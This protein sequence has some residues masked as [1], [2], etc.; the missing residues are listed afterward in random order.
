MR[1][2]GIQTTIGDRSVSV[3]GED[4]EAIRTR[5]TVRA[6]DGARPQ[7]LLAEATAQLAIVTALSSRTSPIEG[8]FNALGRLVQAA[9][10][11]A[12]TAT[13][14]AREV[15]GDRETGWSP[16]GLSQA[17]RRVAEAAQAPEPSG[18][19]EVTAA[20]QTSRLSET[21]QAIRRQ[22]G[23]LSSASPQGTGQAAIAGAANATPASTHNSSM[24]PAVASLSAQVQQMTDALDDAATALRERR[25]SKLGSRKQALELARK[26]AKE[27]TKAGRHH[28]AWKAER[29]RKHEL[30]A[31]EQQT[32]ADRHKRVA[33]AYERARVHAKEARSAY[34][35][36][37]RILGLL[38]SEPD[39]TRVAQ[40]AQDVARLT[41][42]ANVKFGEYRE[43]MEAALPPRAAL[44]AAVPYGRLP[45]MTKMTEVVN[46][47]LGWDLTEDDLDWLLQ[48][49]YRQIIVPADG[50]AQ[51]DH[52][53]KG[54]VLRNGDKEVLIELE[55]GDLEED[56]H[57]VGKHAESI[58]GN[59]PQAA[60]SVSATAKRNWDMSAEVDA[61]A[62]AKLVQPHLGLVQLLSKFLV[63]KGGYGHGWHASDTGSASEFAPPP[64]TVLDNRGEASLFRAP[65]AY[66]VRSR[67]PAGPDGKPG[68]WADVARITEGSPDDAR[69]FQGWVAHAHVEHAPRQTVQMPESDYN[70]NDERQ[71]EMPEHVT[72]SVSGLNPRVD[73][74]MEALGPEHADLKES[75][76]NALKERLPNGFRQSMDLR[77]TTDKTVQ[78]PDGTQKKAQSRSGFVTVLNGD[79]GPRATM[80]VRTRIK[81][82]P[83]TEEPLVTMV[84]T[85]SDKML[86]EQVLI[87]F[88]GASGAAT[89]SRPTSYSLS[90]GGKISLKHIPG[91]RKPSWIAGLTYNHSFASSRTHGLNQGGLAIHPNVQRDT[92]DK[93][94]YRVEMETEI[95]IH[96]LDEAQPLAPI[97][98]D[99][100]ALLEMNESNAY[101]YRW[102]VD[103]AAVP[104]NRSGKAERR[105]DGSAVLRNDPDPA[106]PE[107]RKPEFPDWM[108]S[109]PDQVP[110][111][112]PV[113]VRGIRLDHVRA[114]IEQKFRELHMLPKVVNGVPQWSSN[115]LQREIQILN[116]QKLDEYLSPGRVDASIDQAS[117]D[118]L[119]LD[120]QY[121]GRDH[122]PK[123]ISL[124]VRLEAHGKPRYIGKSRTAAIVN[125]HIGSETAADSFAFSK[126]VST[127][128][129]FG[130][131]RDTTQLDKRDNGYMFTGSGLTYKKEF[132]RNL[133]TTSSRTKN[134]VS[135]DESTDLV[136]HFEQ[137]MTARVDQVLEDGMIRP[138]LPEERPQHVKAEI[139]VSTDL[140]PLETDPV[141][142]A[143]WQTTPMS[144]WRRAT[145][146]ALDARGLLPGMRGLLPDGAS[147]DSAAFHVMA[148]FANVRRLISYAKKLPSGHHTRFAIRLQGTQPVYSDLGVQ[149]DVKHSKMKLV[150]VGDHVGSLVHLDLNGHT[151][152]TGKQRSG[153]WEGSAGVGSHQPTTPRDGKNAGLSRK[154]TRANSQ[155]DTETVGVEDI[156]LELGKHY[157]FQMKGTFRIHGRQRRPGTSMKARLEDR[158][159]IISIPERDALRL[160]ERG[161]LSLPLDQAAD[162]IQRL[163]D[164]TLKL[165]P[166]A[167]G[168]LVER[169]EK[170][171]ARAV[172]QGVQVGK[173][174][175]R[176]ARKLIK[177]LK[178]KVARQGDYGGTEGMKVALPPHLGRSV[179][180]TTIESVE[181]EGDT[182][183]SH[184][185]KDA[186]RAASPRALVKDP[187]LNAAITDVYGGENWRGSLDD[188]LDTNGHDTE[189]LARIGAHRSEKII[190]RVKAFFDVGEARR[191]GRSDEVGLIYQKYAYKQRLIS[192]SLGWI[193]QGAYG[194]E[195]S[196]SDS[197]A[198]IATSWS[199]TRSVGRVEQLTYMQRT[200]SYD[201]TDRIRHGIRF[202]I[203][204]LRRP[205]PA[206]RVR[207]SASHVAALPAHARRA[208]RAA[209]RRG[210][211][212]SRAGRLPVRADGFWVHPAR[213]VTGS[214]V[215]TVP[216]GLSATAD[217][218]L[219]FEAAKAEAAKAAAPLPVTSPDPR[220]AK[221]QRG[222]HLYVDAT[223]ADDLFPTIYARLRR[224]DLL[225]RAGARAVFVQVSQAL[226]AR[227]R[228]AYFRWIAGDQ[229]HLMTTLPKEGSKNKAVEVWLRAVPRNADMVVGGRKDMELS[230]I[231]RRELTEEFSLATNRFLPPTMSVGGGPHG[232]GLKLNGTVGAQSAEKFTS[233]RGRRKEMS[234]FVKGMVVEG[235]YDVDYHVTYKEITFLRDGS[236]RVDKVVEVP[237]ASS[238]TA[239]LMTFD[240][241][242]NGMLQEMEAAPSRGTGWQFDTLRVD[243]GTG[244]RKLPALRRASRA[245]PRPVELTG[246]LEKAGQHADFARDPGKVMAQTL[247]EQQPKIVKPGK[248]VRLTIPVSGTAPMKA[249]TYAQ[250]LARRLGTEVLLDVHEPD[251]VVRGYRAAPS[252]DLASIVPDG[253]FAVAFGTL[254]PDL[255]TVAEESGINLRRLFNGWPGSGT[256][257]DRVRAELDS[258]HVT[259][260]PQVLLFPTPTWG[261]GP[262]KTLGSAGGLS[263]VGGVSMPP[264][265][266]TDAVPDGRPQ[267][268]RSLSLNEARAGVLRLAP[269]DLP[270]GINAMG[271][272]GGDDGVAVVETERDGLPHFVDH[273]RPVI[274][275]TQEQLD[276]LG[277]D[278]AHTTIRSGTRNDPHIVLMAPRVSRKQVPR[279]WLHELVHSLQE[280]EAIR[281]AVQGVIQ[282]L[283]PAPT[284]SRDPAVVDD[285][286]LA[287][288]FIEYP[289]LEQQWRGALTPTEQAYWR[290]EIEGL[291]R[292]IDEHGVVPPAPPWSGEHQTTHGVKGWAGK[293]RDALGGSTPRSTAAETSTTRAPDQSSPSRTPAAPPAAAAPDESTSERSSQSRPNPPSPSDPSMR[294][295]SKDEYWARMRR[296]ANTTGWIPPD[297]ECTCPP[298][299][300]CS[301][302]HTPRS[303]KATQPPSSVP[304]PTQPPSP[305][306]P[307]VPRP[308]ERVTVR[309]NDS[310]WRIVARRLPE[311]ASNAE[312]ARLVHA[313]Y[314]ANR[315][316]IGD[317]P[318]EIEPGQVLTAPPGMPVKKEHR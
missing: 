285:V 36:V 103:A 190:V 176:H 261:P 288:R 276:E 20:L 53:R 282:Q 157:Y 144:V 168:K 279:T 128:G 28:D 291:I 102:P 104:K 240:E 96:L 255:R 116:T 70:S 136:A 263:A 178:A 196:Q 295:E 15:L 77:E 188:M 22:A 84:G 155:A 223:T 251:G 121:L 17:G 314:K 38:P 249:V 289:F 238:G 129:T 172:D 126:S 264:I 101:H 118:G 76:E 318:D 19:A 224:S 69:V 268:E 213:I 274:A 294:P 114:D 265:G 316:I 311:D 242:F 174:I 241:S 287:T 68:E 3:S 300:P 228:S 256:F 108:G 272:M 191:V 60:T 11:M 110:I 235:E 55:L 206:G 293:I 165:D 49:E 123:M 180:Q 237:F 218:I 124:R 182:D 113:S 66:S 146:H 143:T 310:L 278:L 214:I 100:E 195:A 58:I 93:S 41:G 127:G 83:V 115:D 161:E 266:N 309:K 82:T 24:S 80:E 267:G 31:K 220:P 260:P 212:G 16:D 14:V 95:V 98:G 4:L 30:E 79:T 205:L 173:L 217:D 50:D 125:L 91:L 252:G 12:D 239:H 270:P 29:K 313:W 232:T 2:G 197:T 209:L 292:Y 183:L 193:Y 299:Q 130:I 234:V 9:P 48:S 63:L 141:Q 175:D 185:I 262:E 244:S 142:Q 89:T 312:I 21:A 27:A 34:E 229:G 281:E 222:H 71:N 200:A 72:I 308:R 210:R 106:P 254:A 230:E 204:V 247:Q 159:I 152:T 219:R 277:G 306:P 216:D 248:P 112:G 92:S 57:P 32:I 148:A 39:T 186:V 8:A 67:G 187:A 245:Q 189:F 75:V 131:T 105:P 133:G 107:G 280:K 150:A 246:L 145:V 94:T 166:V 258:M 45:H 304:R 221:L 199:H 158:T 54:L 119:L 56:P 132:L 7:L 207:R 65:A 5:L 59:F 51:Q 181:L 163:A 275:T 305:E 87:S 298:G 269:A 99:I 177:K 179:G 302:P 225:G 317:N 120:F 135:L 259:L 250:L 201:G 42:E 156:P 301:H 296:I 194:S 33:G 78:S 164:G 74:V 90:A 167:E 81:R 257:S 47:E 6:N 171:V 109:G 62:L 233:N 97:K 162:A 303:P 122:I 139:L 153:S 37:S 151:T 169:Y 208:S 52:K 13:K 1:D 290:R 18:A 226:S 25:R 64:G 117:Q 170:E 86:T 154:T 203:E 10:E 236:R 198:K 253:G 192:K 215:R 46:R 40:L 286:C 315:R 88:S 23:S 271:W 284:T 283:Q 111:G 149:L 138:F 61:V 73:A 184:E 231:R 160:Y 137:D 307:P 243:R 227:K 202:E 211:H 134:D 44:P 297:D 140:L 35:E 26:A 43:A 273:Y 85:T 147:P